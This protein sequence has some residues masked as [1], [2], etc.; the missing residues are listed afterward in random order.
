MN[1]TLRELN[2]WMADRQ[3]NPEPRAWRDVLA[4]SLLGLLLGIVMG[5]C[6]VESL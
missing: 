1:R 3:R 5:L 6:I 2:E 4:S